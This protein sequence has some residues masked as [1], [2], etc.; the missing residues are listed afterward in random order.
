MLGL[1]DGQ[2]FGVLF[3]RN[4]ELGPV[5][6]DGV[7]RGTGTALQAGFDGPGEFGLAVAVED[8][9]DALGVDVFGVQEESVHVEQTGPDGREAGGTSA[10]CPVTW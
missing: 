10:G 5:V 8:D 4:G 6:E 9:V 7:G 2:V 3:L 1:D